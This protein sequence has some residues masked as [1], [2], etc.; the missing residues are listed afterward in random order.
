MRIQNGRPCS[1]DMRR[2]R[3]LKWGE[4]AII[5]GCDPRPLVAVERKSGGCAPRLP[6]PYETNEY[7]FACEWDDDLTDHLEYRERH[8]IDY[9]DIARRVIFEGYFQFFEFLR[10]QVDPADA[11]FRKYPYGGFPLEAFHPG[12]TLEVLKLRHVGVLTAMVKLG[13]F[14]L[15]VATR[16]QVRSFQEEIQLALDVVVRSWRRAFA[17]QKPL[18]S[19]TP[20]YYGQ[21]QFWIPP[22][23]YT[24]SAGVIEAK[25]APKLL[26][27]P[28]S[29]PAAVHDWG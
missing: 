10:V 7:G 16:S 9:A 18:S 11:D 23:D 29:E 12:V 25:S 22:H 20:E 1:G 15:T 19:D 17:E 3:H 14:A 13:L 4:G 6:E 26:A 8:V 28:G 24:G 27:K 2:L 5:D 21:A